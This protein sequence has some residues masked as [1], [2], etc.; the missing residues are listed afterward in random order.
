MLS[1]SSLKSIINSVFTSIV[2]YLIFLTMFYVMQK[3]KTR[4]QFPHINIKTVSGNHV[5]FKIEKHEMVE[6]LRE[7]LNDT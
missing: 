7:V 4:L 5:S 2:I 6:S 3:G 1:D